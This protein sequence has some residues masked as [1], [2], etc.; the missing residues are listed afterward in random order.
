MSCNLI[1]F[2]Y[3]TKRYYQLNLVLFKS[4]IPPFILLHVLNIGL[5]CNVY[6]PTSQ[7]GSYYHIYIATTVQNFPKFIDIL[8][9]SLLH[10]MT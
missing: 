6:F 10:L 7:S 2:G 3:A 5:N 9:D 1:F 8:L 4:V